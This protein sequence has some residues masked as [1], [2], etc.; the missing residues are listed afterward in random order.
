MNI[1][2]QNKRTRTALS[3]ITAIC[4]FAVSALLDSSAA[5]AAPGRVILL[6][7]VDGVEMARATPSFLFWLRK[8][9]YGLNSKLERDFR[10]HFKA[11]GLEVEAYH[12]ANLSLLYQ[13]L[14]SP[15][16]VGVYWV[17][18]GA[19]A[20][21][22]SAVA[23]GGIFDYQTYDISPLLKDVHPN[24]KLISI[25]S[26]HSAA[27]LNG[28][29][30]SGQ[31]SENSPDLR[32]LSY[33]NTVDAEAGLLGALSQGDRYIS[34]PRSEE[35]SARCSQTRTGIFVSVNRAC[36]QS[37]PALFLKS[38]DR[39]FA[40]FSECNAGQTQSVSGYLDVKPDD[41]SDLERGELDPSIFDVS[42][43]TG[44]QPVDRVMMLPEP[45]FGDISVTQP[46]PNGGAFGWKLLESRPG[47]ALGVNHQIFA[48]QGTSL[49]A[50]EVASYQPFRCLTT[51]P[52]ESSRAPSPQ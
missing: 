7:S 2:S 15:E 29:K 27:I 16:Y 9:Y 32:F 44:A 11:S 30:A 12:Y 5:F 28:L 34:V 21:G 17:S 22:D 3:S 14:R 13:I 26:C 1:R 52:A 24:L 23:T 48:Y 10:E 51:T 33:D 47:Q 38:N 42:V 39:V 31:L 19:D 8:K 37:G 4:L 25:V 50:A 43:S 45:Y 35:Q 40:S 18:H 36:K 41:L 20:K 46:G 6:T 49:V